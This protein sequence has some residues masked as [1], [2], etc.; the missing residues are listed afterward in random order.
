MPR[1]ALRRK[2]SSR[3]EA[4]A[5]SEPVVIEIRLRPGTS[6]SVVTELT[7]RF[8]QIAGVNLASNDLQQLISTEPTNIS[9][10]GQMVE[11]L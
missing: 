4:N 2:P 5:E 1:P 3:S 8:L 6:D 10:Q 9:S 11:D 7:E